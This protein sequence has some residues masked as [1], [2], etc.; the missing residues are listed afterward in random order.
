MF[1][2]PYLVGS[3][4]LSVTLGCVFAPQGPSGSVAASPLPAKAPG[5][6]VGHVK[7]G[8]S[9]RRFRLIVPKAYDATRRLPLVVVLHGWSLSGDAAV[10]YTGF[11]SKAEEKGF[12]LAAPDGL[13]DPRGW[14]AGFLDLS[15]EGKDDAQFVKDVIED[16][17]RQVGVDPARIFVVGHSNGAMLAS[18]VGSRYGDRIAAIGVVS[19]TIGVPASSRRSATL[20]PNI[21]APLSVMIIHGTADQIVTYEPTMPG[22]LKGVGAPQAADWWVK[23]LGAVPL[24]IKAPGP[25]GA[26]CRLWKGGKDGSEVELVT[27][28]GGGHTWPTASSG[29]DATELL[30]TFFA[31]HPK[32]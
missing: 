22:L 19:G 28:P 1:L 29:V 23:Q 5:S 27:I 3:L 13:G 16:C 30:W 12:F 24:S 25:E 7:E 31:A 32:R 14:N 21:T 6:Y 2:R 15:G 11:G 9:S 17:K 26:T 18:L 4:L 8:E 20:I 10:Q